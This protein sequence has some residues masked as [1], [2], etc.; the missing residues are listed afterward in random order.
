MPWREGL[1]ARVT[2]TGAGGA[3]ASLPDDKAVACCCPAF[4]EYRRATARRAFQ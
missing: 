3:G 4:S 1:R 2:V